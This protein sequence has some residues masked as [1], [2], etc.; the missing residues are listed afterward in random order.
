MREIWKLKK[1]I[2]KGKRHEIEDCSFYDP[3]RD[4][5]QS[6]SKFCF[7]NKNKILKTLCLGQY[8]G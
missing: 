4:W 1:K 2:V 5:P 3:P 8:I 6:G 7:L